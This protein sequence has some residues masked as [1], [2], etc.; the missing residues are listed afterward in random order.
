[1]KTNIVLLTTTVL[2][3]VSCEHNINVIDVSGV[4]AE[5]ILENKLNSTIDEMGFKISAIALETSEES[6]LPKN[7]HIVCVN[8]SDIYIQSARIIYRFGIDGH[9]KNT[10]GSVGQGPLEHE[11]I[12]N[13]IINPENNTVAINANNGRIIFWSTDGAALS[14][15]K[16][17]TEGYVAGVGKLA[18]G[19][20]AEEKRIGS[21]SSEIVVSHFDN[22]G[23]RT[24][25]TSVVTMNIDKSPSYYD[26]PIIHGNKYFNNYTSTIYDISS[27][28]PVELMAIDFGKYTPDASKLDDY[29]Y[30]DMSRESTAELLDFVDSDNVMCMM[31]RKGNSL[32]ASVIDKGS[33][34]IL[35]SSDVTDPRRGG[36]IELMS[37]SKIWVW[38]SYGSGDALYSLSDATSEPER[39]KSLLTNDIE[40]STDANPVVIVMHR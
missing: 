22:E 19:Y 3:L 16:L 24:G 6:L 15:T 14:E 9:F 30:R 25:S 38:P 5:C 13:S 4:N 20:W 35:L 36:G 39:V 31:M 18:D 1:M 8:D 11:T 37:G 40:L 17:E 33:G 10:I 12:R 28:T 7:A 21:G 34:T 23:K 29:D 26:T 27:G 2:A 32:W